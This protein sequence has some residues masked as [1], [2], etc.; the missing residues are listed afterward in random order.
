MIILGIKCFLRSDEL[1]NVKVEDFISEY[2]VVHPNKLQHLCLQVEGKCD[3]QPVLLL[4]HR[5]DETPEF[6]PVRI[7][8]SYAKATGIRSGYLF[9]D[10]RILSTSESSAVPSEPMAYKTFLSKLKRVLVHLFDQYRKHV[11]SDSKLRVGTHTLRKTG[12]LFAIW[13]VK[14]KYSTI[15]GGRIIS[16]VEYSEILRAARHKT[17]SNAT[18]YI[19]DAGTVYEMVQNERFQDEQRVCQWRS[20]FVSPN[21]NAGDINVHSRPYQRKNLYDQAV[22]YFDKEVLMPGDGY[23]IKEHYNRAMYLP[24]SRSAEEQLRELLNGHSLDDSLKR[25]ISDLFALQS[26]ERAQEG[27]LLMSTAT[28]ESATAV[29]TEDSSNPPTK[30]KRK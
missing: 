8:L 13:G 30:R 2:Y 26:R 27:E 16:D 9:P 29:V 22:W 12:Y 6:C 1:L 19:V 15:D 24:P 18:G 7:I 28:S 3:E 25:K 14:N 17:I 5:D 23:T 20:V 11:D 10:A 4:L 21:T